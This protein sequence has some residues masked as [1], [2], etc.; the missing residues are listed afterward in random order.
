MFWCANNDI[1]SLPIEIKDYTDKEIALQIKNGYFRYERESADIL[2]NLDIDIYKNEI[3]CIMGAN[4]AG[5]TTLLRILSGVKKLYKGKYRLWNKKIKEYKGDSLYRNNIACVPQN[6]QHLFLKSSVYE[7]LFELTKIL[8]YK[9]AD[10][11]KLINEILEKLQI[12]HLINQHPYDLSG[13]EQQ[14]V[15]LAKILIMNP[16]IILFDEPTKGLDA[17]SKVQFANVINS[18][19]EEGK[20]III[21]THDIEFAAIHADRCAMFFDGQIVSID[22]SVNFFST[23]KYYTTQAARMTRSYYYNAITTEMAIKLCKLNER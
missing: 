6:P 19:K 2:N 21:V 5:K 14:K 16:K 18:L 3:L 8:S 15:A 7:D 13:G 1:K 22:S 20:T 10:G 12:K 17:Y 9:K 4:G 23:N 11:E